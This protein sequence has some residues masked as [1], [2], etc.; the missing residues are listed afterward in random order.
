MF[1]RCPSKPCAREGTMRC[2]ISTGAK[3]VLRVMTSRSCSCAQESLQCASRH[4]RER[5]VM[6]GTNRTQSEGERLSVAFESRFALKY[7]RMQ[8]IKAEYDRP[9]EHVVNSR[10]DRHREATIGSRAIASRSAAR[11]LTREK[12]SATKLES[13]HAGVARHP[14]TGRGRGLY[15]HPKGFAST[16]RADSGATKKNAK[17]PSPRRGGLF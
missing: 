4:A 17:P 11:P 6:P 12:G 14:T 7:R 15:P 2:A 10:Q 9:S 8:R 3:W 5:L 13:T 16:A 1:P